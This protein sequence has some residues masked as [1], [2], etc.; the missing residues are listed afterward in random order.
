MQ[1]KG[2]Q[3]FID[4]FWAYVRHPEDFIFG[5]RSEITYGDDAFSFETVGCSN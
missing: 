5:L 4:A 3:D 2:T 1:R